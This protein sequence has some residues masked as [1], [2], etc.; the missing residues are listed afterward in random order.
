VNFAFFATFDGG[1]IMSLTE[2]LAIK[3]RIIELE[4][5]EVCLCTKI[6]G[7]AELLRTNC[8]LTLKDSYDQIDDQV[9]EVFGGQMA[10]DVRE[11]REVK[12]KIKELREEISE[13]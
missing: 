8:L 6:R 13:C 11:L 9:V 7:A 12:A 4:E 1:V 3:G 10:Q 5:K 2:R